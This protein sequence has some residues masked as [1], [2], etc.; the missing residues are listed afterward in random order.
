MTHSLEEDLKKTLKERHIDAEVSSRVKEDA[1]ITK[2]LNRRQEGLL[3]HGGSGFN[4]YQDIFYEMHDLS[5]LRIVLMDRED[6]DTALKL[7][8][9]LF[10]HQKSPAHFH[11]SREIGQFW[12]RPWFG[13]YETHNHRLQ[14]AN[15]NEAALGHNHQYSGVMFEIQITT[16]S[17]NLYNKLAH[18]LLYKADPGLVTGQEEMVIDVSHGLARCFE[19]CMKILRPKLHRDTNN[20]MSSTPDD[21][22]GNTAQEVKLAQSAVKDFERDLH[23]QSESDHTAQLLRKLL[24]K[25]EDAEDQ[26]CLKDLLVSDPRHDKTRIEETKGGLLPRSYVWILE[27]HDFQGWRENGRNKPVWI[28]GA[29]GKGKTMMLCGI[30]NELSKQSG[31]NVSYFFCQGTDKRINTATSVLR[32]LLFLLCNQQHSLISHIRDKYDGA[33]GKLFEDTNAWFAISGLFD[34]VLRDSGL[35]P[36]YLIVDALDECLPDSR[37]LLLKL[38]VRIANA[39]PT[40]KWIVSSRELG[41]FE[42]HLREATHLSLE[43]RGESVSKAVNSYINSKLTKLE[44][45]HLSLLELKTIADELKAKSEGTF[46]WVAIVCEELESAQEYEVMEILQEMPMGLNELYGKLVQDIKALKRRN[47]TYC[48]SVLQAVAVAFRPLTVKE[49]RELA[50]LPRKV[51]AEAVIKMCRSL[52]TLRDGTV[53]FVHQS[54]KDYLS[55]EWH[56]IFQSSIRDTHESM[57]SKSVE[58]MERILHEDMLY[59]VLQRV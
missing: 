4:S 3:A 51:P 21:F 56:T 50:D 6:R 46:L 34:N 9:E 14:L 49:L 28:T 33:G 25:K 1:S 58:A 41:E 5:G 19:L 30:I 44:E 38:I 27:D 40:V 24:S 48:Q 16:F 12:R 31:T 18:D 43:S 29:P 42:P 53:F 45:Q 15:D 20:S 37:Q 2:T 8:E 22:R 55:N 26:A 10:K 35:R 7:I 13:A 39:C 17:D 54:A 57:F 23:N 11:P 47:P 32:G 52:L 36:T 59:P